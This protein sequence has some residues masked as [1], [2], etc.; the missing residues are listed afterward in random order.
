MF[1]FLPLSALVSPRL[2]HKII[3]G[4]YMVALRAYTL[5]LVSSLITSYEIHQH[6]LG[7]VIALVVV[8]VLFLDYYQSC[9]TYVI[10]TLSF[11]VCTE[12]DIQLLQVAIKRAIFMP[13]AVQTYFPVLL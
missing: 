6:F 7:S 9:Y 5:G 10:L 3:D 1:L 12:A 13:F 2:K 8:P 11:Q 4:L